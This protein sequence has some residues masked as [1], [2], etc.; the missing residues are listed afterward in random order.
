M[1]SWVNFRYFF[2]NLPS[3]PTNH[4]LNFH[5][6]L[7][8]ITYAHVIIMLKWTPCFT[9]PIR[10][11]KWDI[12]LHILYWSLSYLPFCPFIWDPYFNRMP[13]STLFSAVF[14]SKH[15]IKSKTF[16]FEVASDG[17]VVRLI[18]FS[19]LFNV[20]KLLAHSVPMFSLLVYLKGS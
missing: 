1:C 5:D 2:L 8:L 19:L 3:Q 7:S 4:T 10:A 16:F 13:S 14:F 11:T 17:S 12:H 15:S 9:S 20:K 6:S 18:T